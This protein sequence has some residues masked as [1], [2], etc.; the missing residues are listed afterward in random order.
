MSLRRR[1]IGCGILG[2]WA[3]LGR[4]QRSLEWRF[5]LVGLRLAL[6][7]VSGEGISIEMG[8]WILGGGGGLDRGVVISR[9]GNI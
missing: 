7:P 8:C 1:G 9:V 5:R 3:L 4:G 2:L 6:G